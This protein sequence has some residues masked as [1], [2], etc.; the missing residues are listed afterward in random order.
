[1][2]KVPVLKN[3]INGNWKSSSSGD[4]FD[5]VN[6]ANTSE[7][8]GRF[9][10]ST[11]KDVDEAVEAAATALPKWKNTPAPQR[12]E[13]LFRVAEIL[14]KR[15]KQLAQD[16]TREVG[17]IIKETRG[18]VQEAIDMAYYAAGEGR[19]LLG[20]TVPSELNNKFN[21]SVRMPVGVVA[22]ITPWNFP[23]AIPS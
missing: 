12:G 1:M 14:V 9:Q 3:Y 23:M 5:N 22:A 8:V 15:K 10:Q 17:K 4:T 6:P 13:I 16:M 7:V 11:C 2:A 19:R 21:M 20:E 18:D